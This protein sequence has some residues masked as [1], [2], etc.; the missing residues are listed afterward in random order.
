MI[1]RI[2]LLRQRAQSLRVES[3]RAVERAWKHTMI[4]ASTWIAEHPSI[5]RLQQRLIGELSAR[6]PQ[7][8]AVAR[9]GSVFVLAIAALGAI[10]FSH[11]VRSAPLAPFAA[12]TGRLNAGPSLNAFG[13]S[14]E[15]RLRFT[16]PA[17]D[18]EF[19]LEVTGDPTALTYEWVT[20][21][22]S[23]TIEAPRP[24]NGSSFV[25]PTKP[26]FYHL[27]IVRG[28][29]RQIIGEPTLAV[30]V[31]F[32]E[33]VGGKLNGYRIG[34]YLAERL[35]HHD[36]PEG[37]L[38]VGLGDLGL[39]VSTHL[40]LGDFI[41]HDS[42]ADVWPKYVA[43]NPRLLDKLELVLATIGARAR[44]SVSN[45]A[46]QEVAFDVHS[47]FRTPAHNSGVWRAATD[48]RHQYG[49]AADL[50]IDAD[51]D[52]RVT[53]KDEMLVVRAVDQVEDQFPDLVGGLG[54]YTS[55]YYSTPYVHIDTRGTR[56]RWKG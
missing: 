49:D 10:Q 8:A 13:P 6:L 38:E 44:V 56:S 12:I 47:G 17:S 2:Q 1:Q 43:L 41:T 28:L 30:L 51:G 48:S 16:L 45:G 32:E 19:P 54:L 5:Q 53:V 26:G 9:A 31:P 50:A 33:K 29:E 42:Q 11:S 7:G 4:Q 40:R 14:R 46:P 27:A 34:T 18:V 24:I 15:V 23:S 39:K 20:S 35:G 22:D 3:N 52:G 37:F 55:G 36:H 25:A 21:R